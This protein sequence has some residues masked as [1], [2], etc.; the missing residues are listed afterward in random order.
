[1]SDEK[2][3][4]L[5]FEEDEVVDPS[6]LP[7][8][9]EADDV[10]IEDDEN[11]LEDIPEPVK[12][13]VSVVFR[14]CFRSS[15]PLLLFPLF[16]F[17]YC[18]W[19]SKLLLFLSLPHL[20]PPSPPPL[21]WTSTMKMIPYRDSSSTQMLYMLWEWTPLTLASS[22]LAL[23][24]RLRTSL[25]FPKENPSTTSQVRLYILLLC[26]C[27]VVSLCFEFFYRCLFAFFLF[28]RTSPRN[29]HAIV[30]IL[31]TLL[32]HRTQGLHCLCRLE[33]RWSVL[34]YRWYGWSHMYFQDRRWKSYTAYWRSRWGDFLRVASQRVCPHRWRSWWHS[35]DVESS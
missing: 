29:S 8:L 13:V 26:L 2:D 21:R 27:S 11:P 17:I 7:S 20:S 28:F 6:T 30:F 3:Q 33:S 15:S 12:Q 22:L 14:C 25:T 5:P 34:C 24:T 18:A 4:T 32:N 1:M 10:I 19:F 23:V 31:L 35:L 16:I 9:D